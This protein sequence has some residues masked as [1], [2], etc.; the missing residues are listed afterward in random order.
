MNRIFTVLFAAIL[1]SVLPSCDKEIPEEPVPD[2][3]TERAVL[4]Y[5]VASNNLA[6]YLKDD[7]S[8][9][10]DAAASIAGLGRK[11]RVLLYSVASQS[12]TEANLE[13]LTLE[14]DSVWKFTPVKSYDRNTFSTDPVRMREVFTDVYHLVPADNYG[15]VFWSHGTGWVPNFAEHDVPA[16]EGMKKSF[17]ADKYQGV[18]DYCDIKELARAIPDRMF[19]YVWFDCCYMMG[20]ETVYQ[21]RNKC[22]FVGG[23]PTEDW[24]P[25]MNYDETLPLLAAASPDLAAVG[26]AFFDYYNNQDYAVTVSVMKTEG[27]DKL[28]EAAAAIYSYG[29]RPASA[30]GI[31][32]YSRLRVGM[33]DFGQ[34]TKKYV[35]ETD[36]PARVMTYAFDT[37]LK[38]VTVY[39]GCGTKDFN[40]KADAFDPEI[41]SGLS[42][43]FP[44]TSTTKNETYYKSLDWYQNTKP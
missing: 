13:E 44:G 35:D 38:E 34:F 37:A 11:V 43:Y 7:K 22:S 9:M 30:A 31:Q 8:E 20:I 29:E 27:L 41:F 23:Y 18:T 32:N 6:S 36:L 5:A 25:G 15:L 26:K 10:V 39:A 21:L 24:N 16:P 1:L 28:A 2:P 12:A 19:D 17:G 33:Y 14:G 4:I 3:S 40:N 42:C